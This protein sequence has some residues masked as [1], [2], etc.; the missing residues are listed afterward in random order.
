[1]PSTLQATQTM[2]YLNIMVSATVFATPTQQ[3]P[4]D[5][6]TSLPV[7]TIIIISTVIPSTLVLLMLVFTLLVIILIVRW[8]ITRKQVD[9]PHEHTG[10]PLQ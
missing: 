7:S 4:T 10:K 3:H 2:S 1:M 8:K 5:N 9:I 6:Q